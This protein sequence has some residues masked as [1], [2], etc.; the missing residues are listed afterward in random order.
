MILAQVV[1][2]ISD[3]TVPAVAVGLI[4]WVFVLLALRSRREASANGAQALRIHFIVLVLGTAFYLLRYPGMLMIRNG[5]PEANIV[6]IEALC[7][8]TILYLAFIVL[9]FGH[10][11]LWRLPLARFRDDGEERRR[12]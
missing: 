1:S 5:V 2:L 4:A 6:D 8:N 9:V 3:V 7:V 12:L 11:I 10:A